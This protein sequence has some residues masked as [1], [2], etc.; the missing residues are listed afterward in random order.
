ME[1]D[2]KQSRVARTKQTTKKSNPELCTVFDH[3]TYSSALANDLSNARGRIILGAA[4]LASENAQS[5]LPLLQSA[6]KRGVHVCMFIRELPLHADESAVIGALMQAGVHVAQGGEIDEPL[7]VVDDTILWTGSFSFLTGIDVSCSLGRLERCCGR[8]PVARALLLHR[9]LECAEQADEQPA[10]PKSQLG[11]AIGRQICQRRLLLG[12]TQCQLAARL[13][14]HQSLIS[15]IE[16]GKR[17]IRTQTLEKLCTQLE[18][19][20]VFSPSHMT[21]AVKH[22]LKR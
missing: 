15:E 2:I 14:V 22:L 12:L 16:T 9:L 17:N 6:V 20:L 13:G 7:I 3:N 11:A 1:I 8:I 10:A 19:D 4:R 18:M 21:H 5:W